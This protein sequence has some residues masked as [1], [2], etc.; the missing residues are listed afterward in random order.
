MV[1]CT[2]IC[3]LKLDRSRALDG[4]SQ[5]QGSDRLHISRAPRHDS[6]SSIT[7]KQL[8]TRRTMHW[9][10]RTT[11]F[12]LR[13]RSTFAVSCCCPFCHLSPRSPIQPDHHA[14]SGTY[15]GTVLATRSSESTMPNPIVSSLTVPGFSVNRVQYTV[16]DPNAAASPGPACR[17]QTHDAG[18][19]VTASHPLGETLV[20]YDLMVR[21]RR[22]TPS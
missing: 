21:I 8:H 7:P 17:Y 2:G 5:S 1:R 6:T 19:G 14:S 20:D 10:A 16:A 12:A 13:T 4:T 3:R 18:H 15:E 11:I 9:H 22:G